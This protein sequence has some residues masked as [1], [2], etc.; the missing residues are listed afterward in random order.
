[1]KK[2]IIIAFTVLALFL[3]ACHSI[4]EDSTTQ[5]SETWSQNASGISFTS[6]FS[7]A[8]VPEDLPDKFSDFN[9][10]LISTPEECSQSAINHRISDPVA[11]GRIYNY[12]ESFWYK[13]ED[14]SFAFDEDSQLTSMTAKSNRFVTEK[15]VRVGDTREKVFSLYPNTR[16]YQVK[17]ENGYIVFGF[18]DGQKGEI[19]EQWSLHRDYNPIYDELGGEP[20]S[21]W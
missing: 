8:L 11:D 4:A 17:V 6:D 19:L 21:C 5:L 14:V 2:T 10:V 3:S 18:G 9:I 13:C 12:D 7:F 16:N 20:T 15:G 1:M